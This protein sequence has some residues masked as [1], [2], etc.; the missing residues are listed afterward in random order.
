MKKAINELF[1]E[2]ELVGE[3]QL[4]S[5][6]LGKL[7][8]Q[9]LANILKIGNNLVIHKD[10]VVGG[11]LDNVTMFFNKSWDLERGLPEFKITF[12]FNNTKLLDN[13]PYVCKIGINY[14]YDQNCMFFGVVYGKYEELD[15][16]TERTN[17]FSN[18][19]LFQY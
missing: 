5:H 7:I 13:C 6:D 15:Q 4:A 17:K 9:N 10:F 12:C 16:I 11:I 1:D 14:Q 8:K 19:Q 3:S 2:S 18:Q